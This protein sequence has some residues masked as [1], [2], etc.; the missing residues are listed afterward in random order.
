MIDLS[1][2][3][4]CV[5]NAMETIAEYREKVLYTDEM[6]YE[7]ESVNDLKTIVPKASYLIVSASD[8]H[9][10][11]SRI[12]TEKGEQTDYNLVGMSYDDFA[13]IAGIVADHAKA[14]YEAFLAEYNK[15]HEQKVSA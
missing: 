8:G 9:V 2:A 15:E 13:A 7:A 10:R 6:H 5:Q 3:P 1:K 12:F 11:L 4:K 14:E